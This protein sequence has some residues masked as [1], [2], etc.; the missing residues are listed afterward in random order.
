MLL[1]TIITSIII[2]LLIRIYYYYVY[3]MNIVYTNNT[4]FRIYFLT[5]GTLL[6]TNLNRGK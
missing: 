4:L 1:K 6:T 2:I 5:R 3:S